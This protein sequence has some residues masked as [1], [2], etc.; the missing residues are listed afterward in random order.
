MIYV[1]SVRGKGFKQNIKDILSMLE[2]QENTY[3]VLRYCYD[4]P[5]K[6][7]NEAMDLLIECKSLISDRR[8]SKL[9][10][11]YE[12]AITAGFSEWEDE[13][14]ETIEVDPRAKQVVKNSSILVPDDD[15]DDFDF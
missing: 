4:I 13:Y 14:I 15:N 11:A 9:V 10:K 5:N 3:A 8:L 12:K 2:S 1:A 7:Y 6:T